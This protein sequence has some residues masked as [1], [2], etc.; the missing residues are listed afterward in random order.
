MCMEDDVDAPDGVDIDGDV[1]MERDGEDG[2]DEEEEDEREEEVLDE[3]EEENEDNG[4]EPR[5]IGQGEMVKTSADDVDTMVDDEPTVL[6]EQGQEMREHTPR[7]QP[8]APA[9]RLQTPE[10]PPRPRTLETHT[11]SGT[12]VFGAS[13][14]AKTSPR[15]ANSARSW[16][17]RK[18]LGC[19]CGAAATRRIGRWRRSPRWPS[20]GCPSPRCPSPRCP[21]PRCPSPRCPSPRCSSP[22]CPSPRYPSPWGTPGWLGRR[23]VYQSSTCRGGVRLG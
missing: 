2:E 20:P 12:G 9:P 22:R 14:A 13:D 11:L 15:G 10:P 8:P 17:S 21:S 4:K 16:G 1:D 23:G 3:D 5:T 18:H 6:P 7:P 19:R